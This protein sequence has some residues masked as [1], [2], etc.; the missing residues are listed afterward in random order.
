MTVARLAGARQGLGPADD[1]GD[2]GHER[3]RRQLG[4][5]QRARRADLRV[6]STRRDLEHAEALAKESGASKDAR[7]RLERMRRLSVL[8]ERSLL[9]FLKTARLDVLGAFQILAGK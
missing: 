8:V 7:A 3:G 1:G 6:D 5:E 9:A 2:L 4:G